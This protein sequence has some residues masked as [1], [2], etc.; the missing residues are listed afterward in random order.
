MVG[1]KAGKIKGFNFYFQNNDRLK[2]FQRRILIEK[3][4]DYIS[5]IQNILFSDRSSSEKIM[6]G[7]DYLD[8]DH[9]DLELM[10]HWNEIYDKYGCLIQVFRTKWEREHIPKEMSSK[11]KCNESDSQNPLKLD[12]LNKKKSKPNYGE[13]MG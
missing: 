7:P 4:E 8:P 10:E 5:E 1:G 6:K 9:H 13:L 3:S 11:N 2:P 12:W